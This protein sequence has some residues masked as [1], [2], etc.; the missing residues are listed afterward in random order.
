MRV[1]APWALG[2][3]GWADKCLFILD[4]TSAL[5][6]EITTTSSIDIASYGYLSTLTKGTHTHAILMIGNKIY[7]KMRKNFADTLMW[8]TS[9]A[10]Y[11]YSIDGAT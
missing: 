6:T 10:S 2:L 11:C 1:V 3:G 8:R 4:R 5:K 9:V 7:R